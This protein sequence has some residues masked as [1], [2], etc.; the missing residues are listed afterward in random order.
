MHRLTIVRHSL[1]I[2]L[3]M[4]LFSTMSLGQQQS[5]PTKP[6][7]QSPKCLPGMS[8]E[9]PCG[10]GGEDA[11]MQHQQCIDEKWVPVG[12]CVTIPRTPPPKICIPDGRFMFVLCREPGKVS[13]RK[14][15]CVDGHWQLDAKCKTFVPPKLQEKPS[16]M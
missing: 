11:G 5:L 16:G 9:F 10:A 7:L 14:W 3:G 15:I 1:E 2:V 8:R 13:Y 4:I 6:E 12:A